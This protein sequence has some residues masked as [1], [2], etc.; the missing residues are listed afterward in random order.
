[1]NVL[2]KI[3]HIILTHKRIHFLFIPEELE[4]NIFLKLLISN[5]DR[6]INIDQIEDI[7]HY[8]EDMPEAKNLLDIIEHIREYLGDSICITKTKN[9]LIRIQ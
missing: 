6:E 2:N 3:H 1:M 5:L 7:L 8:L 4:L 9:R